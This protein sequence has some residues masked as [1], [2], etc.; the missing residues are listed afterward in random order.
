MFLRRGSVSWIF[1]FLV[2]SLPAP[3]RAALFEQLAVSAPAASLGNA[4]TAYPE[5]CG[6]MAIHYNPALLTAFEGTRL[7][8]G[9]VFGK[10]YRR[11]YFELGIDPATGQKWTPFGDFFGN[12]PLDGKRGVIQSGYMVIPIVDYEL[13]YLAG[14]AMGLS[15]KPPDPESRLTFGFGQYA[16]FAVGLKHHDQ[17]PNSFLGKKAFFV[18]MILA[19][20][21]VAY[22][23]TD[24][25]SVGASVGLG[26]SLFS[27]E[28]NMRSP[29]TMVA[30]T[31]ALG[32]STEGLEIP[33]V[34]ELTLPPPWFGGGMS[35]F[36]KMGNIDLMV[37]DYFTTSYNLGLYW[38]P[39]PWFAFG[40][41]YESESDT[42]MTGDY[43]IT[44]GDRFQKT[45]NWLGR[46][47]MTII[48]AAM[49]DLP[50]KAVP[51]QKGTASVT[52]KWPSRM[53]MGVKLRPI[54]QLIFTCD[55]NYTDWESWPQ[56]KIDFDQKIQLFRFVRLLGYT[57]GPKAM[58]IN[59]G[60]QN[61]WSLSYGMEIRPVKKLALRFGYDPRPTSVQDNMWGAMPMS[62]MKIYSA[63]IGLNLEDQPKPKP[64]GM[65]ALMQQM[66]HPSAVDL[67]VVYV[68]L[69]DKTIGF[70]EST[71]M[72]ST[73]FT[74]VVYNPY[75]G[76]IWRQE[77]HIWMFS[78]NQVF[79]W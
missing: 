17:D 40:A 33:I 4:V 29:N 62:D 77:M 6:A 41:C 1:L 9:L 19:A 60:F 54:K 45:V 48:V 22:Q 7:D 61:T 34:S 50:N 71:N 27:F 36:E 24:T 11:T 73:D 21:A 64:K 78:L 42:T 13:P 3:V 25:L 70:N 5:G 37:E 44:Y 53:Q 43:K 28:S 57:G 55:A 12:D 8:S 2:I 79:K 20:P 35:P 39:Y 56:V 76:L 67:T 23:A 74:K 15:Y 65:H 14:A 52:M 68:G 66:Q 63:G 18:R 30:L 75:A 58:V 32:K 38:N 72:N 46:S 10:S 47:P 59:N 16:P 51:Y 26:V 31:G 69:K 49:F